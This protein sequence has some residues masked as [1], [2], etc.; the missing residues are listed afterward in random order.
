MNN[1]PH[2]KFV[3]LFLLAGILAL[4]GCKSV[5]QA[6]YRMDCKTSNRSGTC[7]LV[8]SELS[9]VFNRQE[10][11]NQNFWPG[12]DNVEVTVSAQVAHGTV[13]FWLED[14]DKQVTSAIV[15]PGQLIQIQGKARLNVIGDKR[16]FYVYF[17]ALGEGEFKRA[18]NLRAEIRYDMP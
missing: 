3:W 15:E 16:S 7:T 8:I 9:G 18:E 2:I 14:R 12:A 6:D 10:I 4:T 1:Y 13:K 5:G 17:E 11:S